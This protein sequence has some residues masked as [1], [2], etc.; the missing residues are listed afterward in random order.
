MDQKLLFLI[1]REWTNSTLDLCMAAISTFAVWV[2]PIVL[3]AIVIALR[4]GFKARAFL[5]ILALLVGLNDGVISNPLKHFVDRPRPGESVND[6]RQVDLAKAR[7]RILALNKPATVKL[8]RSVFADV[9]GR[10]FPS[11]HTMNMFTAAA[12]LSIAKW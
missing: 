1:N 6:V 4:G 12:V 3:A 11:G 2:W 8:S 7:P 9:D 5:L 10:S